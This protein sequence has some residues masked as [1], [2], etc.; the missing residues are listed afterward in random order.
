MKIQQTFQQ[1]LKVENLFLFDAAVLSIAGAYLIVF[2]AGAAPFFPSQ[3]WATVWALRGFGSVLL[4]AALMALVIARTG[5]R[6]TLFQGTVLFAASHLFLG[7][8]LFQGPLKMDGAKVGS[9]TIR[10]GYC[11][12]RY[13]VKCLPFFENFGFRHPWIGRVAWAMAFVFTLAVV[14][15]NWGGRS[16]RN[17]RSD[18]E[19]RIRETAGQEERNRLARELHDSIKQQIFA[20]QTSVAA[21]QARLANS[22]DG[23]E[24]A[25][26]DARQSAREATVEMETMLDQLQAAP[27]EN[28]G[29]VAAIRKQ[30]E[31]LGFRTGAKVQVEI[32][33]LPPSESLAPGSHQALYRILQESLSNIAKHARAK[34][35]QVNVGND[36]N[37]NLS[38]IIQDDGQGFDIVNG[39]RGMG[40]RNL[41]TRAEEVGGL[42]IVQSQ[43][44]VG[45][46]IEVYIPTNL[47]SQAPLETA[48]RF[49]VWFGLLIPFF[50]GFSIWSCFLGAGLTAAASIY[51][52]RKRVTR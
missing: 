7:L 2:P 47:R 33:D 39:N 46:M 49:L 52:R 4:L 25:L 17:L 22:G 16:A 15:G 32:G 42:V 50:D 26:A 36:D 35:V 34:L 24:A 13:E 19:M 3:A 31:A 11:M 41:Q 5:D 12:G 28:Q 37:G 38:M 43:P 1:L 44:G 20:I 18:W 14:K 10:I 6:R 9:D 29:L 48:L 21:A 40:L 51:L 45:T 27:L 23:I 8:L 30:C